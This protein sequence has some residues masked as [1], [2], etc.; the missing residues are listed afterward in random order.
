MEKKAK[1]IKGA[2]SRSAEFQEDLGRFLDVDPSAWEVLKQSSIDAAQGHL[3]GDR[4][5]ELATTLDTT[6]AEAQ[7]ITLMH[8][9]LSARLLDGGVP[10]DLVDEIAQLA[11]R[12]IDGD[13][14]KRLADYLV[15]APHVR[16][17][18]REREAFTFG[19]SLASV[20]TKSLVAFHLDGEPFAGVS[21]TVNYLDGSSSDQSMSVN[22]SIRELR[23]IANGLL[24]AADKAEAELAALR[25]SKS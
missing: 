23:A 2:L 16:M 25:G 18:E 13:L 6:E 8:R 7:R 3:L 17:E 21:W 19:N 5:T 24:H 1:F 14:R 12:E 11:G 22:L 15:P 4:L 20:E 9:F 10:G